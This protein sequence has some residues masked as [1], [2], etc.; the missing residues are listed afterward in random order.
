MSDDTKIITRGG[1]IT[2]TREI[3]YFNCTK[4]STVL[5]YKRIFILSACLFF[6]LELKHFSNYAKGI[7]EN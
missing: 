2:T 4:I 5:Y 6:V 3:F 7:S 1:G